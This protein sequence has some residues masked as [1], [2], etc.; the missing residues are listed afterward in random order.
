MPGV[1]GLE[2]LR[3]VKEINRE[4][5]VIIMTAF[6]SVDTAVKALKEGAYDYITKPID[7]EHLNHLVAKAL[8][9]QELQRENRRLKETVKDLHGPVEI[10]GESPEM[11]RVIELIQT[12]RRCPRRCSK[13]SCS[14]TSGERSPERSIDGEGR[15]S[16]RT[17]G[18]CSLMKS[19]T[20]I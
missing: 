15:S 14:G 19:A 20:L 2:L 17:E 4:A 5:T 16:L 3:R 1:D 18:R 10:I 7:P 13:A 8:N 12:A 6:A 9:E 11:H